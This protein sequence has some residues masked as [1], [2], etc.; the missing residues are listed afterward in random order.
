MGYASPVHGTLHWEAW[1]AA[2]AVPAGHQ[3]YPGGAGAPSGRQ[4][5]GLRACL[6]V[7]GQV[8]GLARNLKWL[9]LAE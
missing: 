9:M 1:A 3:G 4:E 7:I 6:Q 8:A 2:C 5:E